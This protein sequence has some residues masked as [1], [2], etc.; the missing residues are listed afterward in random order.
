MGLIIIS[1]HSIN[2]MSSNQNC[3]LMRL[4]LLLSCW[5]LYAARPGHII[6]GKAGKSNRPYILCE[7]IL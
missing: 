1:N 7:P 2:S 5:E 3:N 4:I 6:P